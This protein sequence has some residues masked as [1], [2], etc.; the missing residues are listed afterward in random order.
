[1]TPE[2]FEDDF[3]VWLQVNGVIFTDYK[4]SPFKAM[5]DL[6]KLKMGI[7]ELLMEQE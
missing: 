2:L 7:A 1:M 3:H 5:I 4:D 6:N